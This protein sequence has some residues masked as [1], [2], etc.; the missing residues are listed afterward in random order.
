MASKTNIPLH[1]GIAHP[2]ADTWSRWAR[3]KLAESAFEDSLEKHYW[4]WGNQ[5]FCVLVVSENIA[6]S[7][8]YFSAV[9]KAWAERD[10]PCLVPPDHSGIFLETAEPSLRA[11]VDN[12]GPL[13]PGSIGIPSGGTSGKAS[14]TFH[15][16]RSLIAAVGGWYHFFGKKP[17]SAPASLPF[18][19]VSGL[20]PA[21]RAWLTGGVWPFCRGKSGNDPG[22]VLLSVVP[23]QLYRMLEGKISPP[24]NHEKLIVGGAAAHP[25]LLRKAVKRG[26]SLLLSYGMTE[27][28]GGLALGQLGS[29][30]R[31]ASCGLPLTG[32]RFICSGEQAS[33][34]LL[35]PQLAPWKLWLGKGNL[36]EQ[37]QAL[38]QPFPTGDLVDP[39][40][41]P[42]IR[43]LGREGWLI[44]SGGKKISPEYVEMALGEHPAVERVLVLGLTD[45]EWGSRCVAVVEL[46]REALP[47]ALRHWLKTKI[48]AYAVPREIIVEKFPS[49]KGP[50]LQRA[51]LMEYFLN[52]LQR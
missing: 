22:W 40:F 42:E 29:G 27:T 14:W 5:R 24:A 21:V 36:D 51:A 20:M 10:I 13:P 39:G 43:P 44:N 19:H 11:L 1:E 26:W 30:E 46:S 16:A 37:V 12:A 31:P 25:D 8:L 28:A 35:T 15:D 9:L 34:S 45:K 3:I 48:P 2:D 17:L 18:Y 4:K 7:A 47:E 32:N 52:G 41:I 38:P 6:D 50:K 49:Q 23:T 33:L